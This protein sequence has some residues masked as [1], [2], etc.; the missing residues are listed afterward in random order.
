MVPSTAALV[1]KE[2]FTFRIGAHPALNFR[3]VNV[4]RNGKSEEIIETRRYIA[5][6]LA[7]NYQFSDNMGVGM[8]YLYGRG[9]D[10]GVKQTH[11]LTINSYFNNLH[12]TQDLY[13]D[14]SPQVYY[15]RT[16][17]QEGFYVVGFITFGKEG[18]PL[19]ISTILNKAIETEIVPEDDF[20][21]NVSL[22]YSF[23]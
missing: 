20:V 17:D 23:P 2:R 12:I 3:T 15:L 1:E 9:F 14:I 19:S 4:I 18:F 11:F 7:P 13:F 6:E 21:W 10:E 22:V 5:A 16:D 8:Y